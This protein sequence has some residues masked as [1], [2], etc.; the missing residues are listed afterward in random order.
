MKNIYKILIGLTLL[1]VFFAR[2]DQEIIQADGDNLTDIDITIAGWYSMEC[3]PANFQ[4][5]AG[6]KYKLFLAN[7]T[8]TGVLDSLGVDTILQIP[9]SKNGL[10]NASMELFFNGEPSVRKN[11][12][13]FCCDTMLFDTVFNIACDP[14]LIIECEALSIK[15]EATIA[16]EFKDCI[17]VGNGKL[18]NNSFR[19]VGSSTLRIEYDQNIFKNSNRNIWVDSDISSVDKN[20]TSISIDANEVF[21]LYFDLNRSQYL[22][23]NIFK[24]VFIL[25][26]TC[27][28]DDG[29][30]GETGVIE[31][32][33]NGTLC[34]PVLCDCPVSDGFVIKKDLSY[35]PVMLGDSQT[36]AITFE[37]IIENIGENCVFSIDSIIPETNNLTWLI[38]NISFPVEL[39][40]EGNYS[41]NFTFIPLEVIE[42]K[43]IF[44][45]YSSTLPVDYPEGKTSCLFEIELKGKG[46]ETEC[47]FIQIQSFNAASELDLNDQEIGKLHFGDQ[48]EMSNNNKIKQSMNVVTQSECSFDNY[49]S[50]GI[51]IY[52]LK[53]PNGKDL[54]SDYS[55]ESYE[56]SGVDAKYFHTAKMDNNIVV[57]FLRSE[58]DGTKEIYSSNMIITATDKNGN[59]CSKTIIMEANIEDV[60][61]YKNNIFPMYTF[62]QYSNF[63]QRSLSVFKID[64]YNKAEDNFGTATNINDNGSY[65][66]YNGKYTAPDKDYTLYFEIDHPDEYTPQTPELYLINSSGNQFTHI[67]R[68]NGFTYPSTESF[69]NAYQ[70]TNMVS[71]IF[72][73]ADKGVLLNWTPNRSANEMKFPDGMIMEEGQVYVIWNPLSIKDA[74]SSIYCDVALLYIERINKGAE[75][76]SNN[77]RAIVSFYIQYPVSAQ[78]E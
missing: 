62:S 36:V 33:V 2:C 1:F 56:V 13:I 37:G 34:E 58:I 12:D 5:A 25:N 17:M 71:Q 60:P 15:E 43:E 6:A 28:N 47:P 39:K 14:P 4:K 21:V 74:T 49:L 9:K 44:T 73:Q 48:I 78:S 67:A 65:G 55:I 64:H 26:V 76:G 45:V 24:E 72:D 70:N 75:P 27:I 50:N 22:E 16:S 54:C 18:I 30:D 38:E 35:T 8:I 19:F 40:K 63:F 53:M 10:M 66:F 61:Y 11:F 41:I 69:A 42:Y 7:D 77:D 3:D 57:T 51:L 23:E 59:S 29:S 20:K 46:C 68:L 32:T 52:G 31:Y